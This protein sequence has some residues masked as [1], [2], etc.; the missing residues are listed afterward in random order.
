MERINEFYKDILEALGL[1]VDEKGRIFVKTGKTLTPL[2]MDG[3]QFVLPTKENIENLII[4]DENGK[5]KAAYRFFNPAYEDPIKGV[6][7]SLNKL[8]EIMYRRLENRVVSIMEVLINIAMGEAASPGAIEFIEL[9]N[10]Y[11]NSNIK[12]LVDTGILDALRALYKNST[13][14][15]NPLDNFLHIYLQKG[16]TINNEKYNKIASTQFHMYNR[17]IDFK[18][19]QDDINGIK[20][21]N[22]DKGAILSGYE[23]IF[24]DVDELIKGIIIGSKNNVAPGL[25]SLLLTYD[26]L[27]DKTNKAIEDIK[28][29]IEE[30]LFV[31]LKL[32][33]LKINV[34]DLDK[35]LTEL[36]EDLKFIPKDSEI[37]QMI[38]QQTT[39]GYVTPNRKTV[40]PNQQT[41]QSELDPVELAA[42][43][44]VNEPV[45]MTGG[46]VNPMTP[47]P[48]P[49]QMNN[50]QSQ[51]SNQ[52]DYDPVLMM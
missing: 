5:Y 2:V 35:F 16:T 30:E 12:K 43:E 32:R 11:K 48:Q 41:T 18:V 34:N 24:K 9:L 52:G 46:F 51:V 10:R 20:L 22:K 29:D 27:V 7:V 14:S 3:L 4:K 42:M 36:K 17:L 40:Q 13:S 15:K 21:R 44:S 39:I 50:I 19:K 1:V 49:Q 25:H 45:T 8:R 26:K 28:E 33:K 47:V 31:E 23:Y 37:E 38:Q 6:D